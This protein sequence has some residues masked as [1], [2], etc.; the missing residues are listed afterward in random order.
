MNV[1]APERR[2]VEWPGQGRE[3]CGASGKEVEVTP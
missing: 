2:P 1:D 3:D